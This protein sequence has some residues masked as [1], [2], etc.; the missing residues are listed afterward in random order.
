MKT[1]LICSVVLAVVQLFLACYN[2]NA[3]S[4]CEINDVHT[5]PDPQYV[6]P[7]AASAA[8]PYHTNQF[9]WTR[10]WWPI[11]WQNVPMGIV[12]PPPPQGAKYMHIYSPFYSRK[13]PLQYIAK[14][15]NSDFQ[16]RDGWELVAYDFG[17]EYTSDTTFRSDHFEEGYLILYNKHTSTLRALVTPLAIS[18]SSMAEMKWLLMPRSESYASG[19]F[20]GTGGVLNPL[21]TKSPTRTIST[22]FIPP[23]N[24]PGSW[25]HSETPVFYDPCSCQRDQQLETQYGLITSGEIRLYGVYAGTTSVLESATDTRA[26]PYESGIFQDPKAYLASFNARNTASLRPGAIV[27]KDMNALADNYKQWAKAITNLNQE[28]N[29][30]SKNLELLGEG[31]DVLS[32][33]FSMFSDTTGATAAATGNPAGLK[34]AAVAKALK[35][36][37]V[38]S[39]FASKLAKPK[40]NLINPEDYLPSYSQGEIDL[41]GSVFTNLSLN[42]TGQQIALP[43]TPWT[44]DD[45]LVA[46]F[47]TPTKPQYPL[48]NETLGLFAILHAPKV[49]VSSG[50]SEV[51]S[52]EEPQPPFSGSKTD[53][54]RR[55]SWR[56]YKFG[57]TLDYVWNPASH[58]DVENTRI[59]AALIV[60]QSVGGAA[61][62]FTTPCSQ[63]YDVAPDNGE[64]LYDT[65]LSGDGE[66]TSSVYASEFVGLECLT[67]IPLTLHRAQYC[68]TLNSPNGTG[69]FRSTDTV[70]VR[71]VMDVRFKPNEYGVRNR[72]LMIYT[73]PVNLVSEDDT[74]TGSGMPTYDMDFNATGAISHVSTYK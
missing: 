40:G 43:G 41:R 14:H 13:V 7:A 24:M 4:S 66:P 5:N 39:K 55:R 58:V 64:R 72:S 21:D 53:K 1:R 51:V 67:E 19:L 18:T 38:A 27:A 29:A 62:G 60:K 68:P 70:F 52:D 45:N 34:A 32:A 57:G 20:A 61:N 36:L 11:A 71:L 8:E 35:L 73:L 26:V 17:M 63:W 44:K 54:A 10:R 6:K 47:M 15:A 50:T 25:Y 48:Y 30:A 46:P 56:Q 49:K 28:L 3:Q 42:T 23:P 37:S 2:V 69:Q 74:L 12:N 22:R 65:D 31:L 59:N 16:P 9:D 33:Y